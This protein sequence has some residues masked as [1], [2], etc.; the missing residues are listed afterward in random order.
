MALG[1]VIA[2][3]RILVIMKKQTSLKR[4]VTFKLM[5]Q[6]AKVVSLVGSFTG[7]EQLPVAMQKG[8]DGVWSKT[9][10]LEPGAHEYRL[11][12][13][14]RWQDDPNCP[15]RVPNPFG[16]ENCLMMVA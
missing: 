4:K 1:Y 10:T 7:W 11:V 9:V 15:H 2:T 16:T 12:V 14:G 3:D 13:D 6:E 5:A 8:K